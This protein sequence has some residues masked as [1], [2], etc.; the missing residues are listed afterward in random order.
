MSEVSTPNEYSAFQ[1]GEVAV[2]NITLVNAEQEYVDLTY[3]CSNLK[4]YEGIDKYFVS[5]RISIVDGQDLIKYYKITGQE[6]LTIRL[7]ARDESAKSDSPYKTVVERTFKIYA[8]TDGKVEG[9]MQ[10]YTLSFIDT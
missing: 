9:N 10:Y 4:L 1:Q 2:E 3:V 7:K 5:G 6:S 8:V